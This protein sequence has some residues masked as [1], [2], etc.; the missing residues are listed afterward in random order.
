[1]GC[2]TPLGG[3]SVSNSVST[4]SLSATAFTPIA[5]LLSSDGQKV[6]VVVQGSPTIIVYDLISQLPPSSL[7]LAGNPNPLS[8]ALAPD[9]QTLYVSADDGKVHFIN[10]VSGGDAYQLDVPSSSLCTIASGG[11]QPTCLPDVLAVRP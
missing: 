11:Q 7:S 3:I 2:P 1:L 6:Y 5:F 10:T 8:A 9:D 4:V